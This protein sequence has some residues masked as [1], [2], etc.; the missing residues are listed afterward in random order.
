MP[1]L[2]TV[3]RDKGLRIREGPRRD[4]PTRKGAAA[5][6]RG[7]LPGIPHARDAPSMRARSLHP[8]ACRI[9]V[10]SFRRRAGFSPPLMPRERPVFPTFPGLRGAARLLR[11][12]SG[13][14]VGTPGGSVPGCHRDA[15]AR[16]RRAAATSFDGLKAP[17]PSCGGG[18]RPSVRQ[19]RGRT[20]RTVPAR[21]SGDT[22]PR[23]RSPRV[24]QAPS[25]RSHRTPDGVPAGSQR[26]SPDSRP[27]PACRMSRH[28]VA[29]GIRHP[30]SGP[31]TPLPTPPTA[32]RVPLSE[33]LP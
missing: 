16:P 13:S 12:S 20:S 27:T 17:L 3:R 26:P 1:G 7:C 4:P 15:G 21:I 32:R 11:N 19:S 9:G 6:L 33:V 28:P 14:R 30:Q 8:C 2:R 31:T 23:S 22:I 10:R 24:R 18:P 5:R 29:G 25:W